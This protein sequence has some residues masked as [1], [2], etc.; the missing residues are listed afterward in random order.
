MRIIVND[1]GKHTIFQCLRFWISYHTGHDENF[2]F[3]RI[4][5]KLHC[6]VFAVHLNESVSNVK[7]IASRSWWWSIINSLTHVSPAMCC[8]L[9]FLGDLRKAKTGAV[10][11]Q[12]QR[13][14]LKHVR[15]DHTFLPRSYF[16]ETVSC[17]KCEKLTTSLWSQSSSSSGLPSPTWGARFSAW[18]FSIIFYL[19]VFC[20]SLH[21]FSHYLSINYF[22]F[23]FYLH[24]ICSYGYSHYLNIGLLFTYYPSNMTRLSTI[25]LV[26]YRHHT[27]SYFQSSS[28]KNDSY[29]F[30]H[31][32]TRKA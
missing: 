10:L 28:L 16:Y 4:D 12:S 9:V 2:R 25:S 14:H 13:R 20:M 26:P 3:L 24:F 29:L 11:F 1:F 19:Y 6:G 18:S 32:I 15:V 27:R 21:L 17:S 23:I 7:V 8:Y 30:W 5:V 31:C 22:Y